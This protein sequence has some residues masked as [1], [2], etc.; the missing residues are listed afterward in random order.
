MCWFGSDHPR[1]FGLENKGFRFAKPSTV[2]SGLASRF[3]A[4]FGS[5][6]L[7]GDG[8]LLGLNQP[9]SAIEAD[10]CRCHKRLHHSLVPAHV[11]S[12]LDP[13]HRPDTRRMQVFRDDGAVC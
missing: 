7:R 4:S 5:R 3:R 12:K 1:W 13:Q 11:P 10:V 9:F 2:S 8:L 6:Y